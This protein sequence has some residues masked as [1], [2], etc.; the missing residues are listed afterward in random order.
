MK[1]GIMQPY[2]MPYYGY[3]QLIKFVD[4]YVVYDDV[5][6]IKGGWI[7]RNFIL[8][9]GTKHLFTIPLESSSPNKRINDTFIT[10]KT[11]VREKLIKTLF[12]SY[13]KAK[14]FRLVFPILQSS[15]MN[16]RT[17]SE[18]NYNLICHFSS[19]LKFDT[20]IVLSSNLIKDNSLKGQ[21]K[22]IH[23]VQSLAG[24]HYINA[25]GGKELYSKDDF[26]KEGIVL[27]FLKS[28]DIHYKQFNNEYIP[29]LSFIDLLMFNDVE[30]I[31]AMLD[32]FELI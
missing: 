17:I 24:S 3:W 8:M 10:S 11:L 12:Q 22:V 19:Y 7:N 20:Q 2:F 27:N 6:F 26:F 14:N 1:V 29:N 30:V 23:I 32:N 31:N 15:I 21:D 13:S 18:L 5:N 4:K 16:S 9:N 25:I 28:N